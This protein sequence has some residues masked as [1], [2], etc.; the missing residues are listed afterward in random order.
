[1]VGNSGSGKSRL[2]RAL[3]C[4]LGVHYVELDALFHLPNWGERPLDDFKALITERMAADGWVVDGNYRQ[5]VSDVVWP[6]ADTVVWLDLPRARVMRQVIGRT[7]RRTITREE[8]WSGNREPLRNLY[9]WDP[10]TSIIRWSWTQHQKY[11][12]RYEAAMADPALGHVTFVRLR[13]RADAT[14]WLAGLP[15]P[16]R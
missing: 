12:S 13:S 3:A 2:G 6:K 5:A 1:M 15:P 8:L 9:G 11:V 10:K 14:A 4:R 16:D 7:L